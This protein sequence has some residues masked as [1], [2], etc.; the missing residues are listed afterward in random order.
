MIVM[1]YYPGIQL[2]G[3]PVSQISGCVNFG[4]SGAIKDNHTILWYY[5]ILGAILYSPKS[6]L[7][8]SWGHFSVTISYGLNLHQVSAFLNNLNLVNCPFL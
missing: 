4:K 6:A 2:S 3:H 8:L 5:S 1:N 7:D